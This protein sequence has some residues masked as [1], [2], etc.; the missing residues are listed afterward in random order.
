MSTL[1]IA[2]FC[3]KKKVN[4]IIFLNAYPYGP[5]I[6]LP[7]NED[8]ALQP[9]SPYN[10]SK[11]ISE[12]LLFKYLI[13]KTDVVSLRVFNIYGK[14]QANNFLIP[15]II[16]QAKKN[17]EISLNDLRPK[18]DFLYIKDLV[19]LIDK[20]IIKKS[21]TGI[22]NVGYGRSFSI[23]QITDAISKILD[24]SI[25]LKSKNIIRKNEIL[26][27]FADIK[28]VSSAFNWQ[29]KFSIYEGISDYLRD[30]K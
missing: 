17:G 22:Y 16:N 18:R 29:P 8:H 4:K 21:A 23:K 1:N 30:E 2:E 6:K 7:I 12:E 5:P 20:I 9:H 19:S 25:K 14:L 13:G 11:L 24:K 3:V 28:K 10:S 27:L 15:T 26:D